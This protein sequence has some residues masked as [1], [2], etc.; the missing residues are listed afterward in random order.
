MTLTDAAG[1]A[2]VLMILAA[3]AAATLG[4]L[5]PRRPLALVANLTGAGL[6]LFSLLTERFNLAAAV[7][8]AAWALVAVAGLVRLGV[9][10]LRRG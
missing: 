6:I 10:W 5:D 4:R 8:E 9:G 7:M 3:Y 1:L 2:G